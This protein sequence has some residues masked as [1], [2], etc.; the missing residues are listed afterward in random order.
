MNYHRYKDLW[1][2]TVARN[3]HN[4]VPIKEHISFVSNKYIQYLQKDNRTLRMY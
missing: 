1:F 2:E 3:H 4:G